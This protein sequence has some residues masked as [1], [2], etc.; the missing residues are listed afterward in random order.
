MEKDKLAHLKLILDAIRK[1]KDY[2]GEMIF[3]DFIKDSKTQSA[4]LMQL[5]VIGELVKKVPEEVKSKSNL[6][7]KKM[8]GMR[9][10][11]SHEYFGLDLE[12]VWKTI[13]EDVP[14][15]ETEIKK[16]LDT[17]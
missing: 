16:F 6:P 7:W 12:Q 1:I 5:H 10:M 15:L 13:V 11:I 4:V 17:K 2:I 14:T 8:A 9:D 3:D